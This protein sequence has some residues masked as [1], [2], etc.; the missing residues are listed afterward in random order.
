MSPRDRRRIPPTIAYNVL[1]RSVKVCNT[2][3]GAALWGRAWEASWRRWSGPVPTRIHGRRVT[4]NAGY[5][6]PMLLR[7]WPTYNDPLVETVCRARE[8]AGRAV[9]LVDVGAAVG[10]TALL[11]LDRAG[12]AVEA[13]HCVE[14][15]EE[16]FGLLAANVG[17]LP[18]VQLHRA[19]VSDVRG[20]E[21]ALQRT[22]RGTA[23]AVGDGAAASTTLDEL[24]A[25]APHVDVLKTDTDGFDGKVIAGAAGLLERHRPAVIF[26]WHPRLYVATGNDWKRPFDV[27]ASHGYDRFVWF[28]KFGDFS[29]VMLRPDAGEISVL[30]SVCLDDAGPTRDWHYDVIALHAGSPVRVEDV[31]AL[32]D[33]RI[34]RGGRPRP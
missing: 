34:R 22:H 13:I 6:Y 5:P 21:R 4:V 16:F 33:A 24:L 18:A 2:R 3:I 31:A 28:T 10:D 19:L 30:A 8:A 26:E 25:A 1:N 12:D 7:R 29:H 15:D 11:I 9:T 17:D 27:L 14:G 23:S 20:A 32:R